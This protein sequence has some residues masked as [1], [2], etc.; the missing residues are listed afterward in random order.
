MLNIY[1]KIKFLGVESLTVD[2]DGHVAGFYIEDMS[3]R[4]Y[5]SSARYEVGDY[6]YEESAIHFYCSDVII[7]NLE[8]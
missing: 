5:E 6:E 4:G 8:K 7:E 1:E 3:V 2:S